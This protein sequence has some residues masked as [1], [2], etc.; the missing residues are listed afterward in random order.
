MSTTLANAAGS[1]TAGHDRMLISSIIET[2]DF[3]HALAS[4]AC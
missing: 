2:S 4:T 1:A 3:S